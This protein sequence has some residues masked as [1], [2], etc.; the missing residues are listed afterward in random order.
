MVTIT[1]KIGLMM[2][3]NVLDALYFCQFIHGSE[4][5]IYPDNINSITLIIIHTHNVFPRGIEFGIM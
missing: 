5:C 3:T 1:Q 2:K 4:I